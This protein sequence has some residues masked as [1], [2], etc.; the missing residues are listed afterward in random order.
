M[1]L[2]GLL[3]ESLTCACGHIKS[4]H[5]K[6]ECTFSQCSCKKFRKV[7]E[8]PTGDDELVK[9]ISESVEIKLMVKNYLINLERLKEKVAR[10]KTEAQIWRIR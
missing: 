2:D 10:S 6:Q 3:D 9:L 4:K 8:R 7:K 1:T 5:N